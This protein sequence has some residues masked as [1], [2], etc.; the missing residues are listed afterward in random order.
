MNRKLAILGVAVVLIG[1][2]ATQSFYIVDE[3]EQALIVQFGDPVDQVVEPGLN[4]KIPFIQRVIR[5]DDRILSLD[6]PAEQVILG[7]QRRLVVDSFARFK[8][9]DP[10][11]FY[12][13]VRTLE[14]GRERLARTV[15][16]AVRRVL[17]N[18]TQI[19][20]L[21]DQRSRIMEEIQRQVNADALSFGIDIVDVRLGRVDLPEETEQAVF[22]RMRSERAREAAEFR[23]E[24]AEQATQI[25][26]RADREATVLLAEAGRE[27]QVLRG[28]GEAQSITILA[29]AYNA[30]PEFFTFYRTLQA[31]RNALGSEDTT[32]VLSPDSEFFRFFGDVDPAEAVGASGGA[33]TA[34]TPEPSEGGAAAPA[35]ESETTPSGPTEE[36]SAAQPPEEETVPAAPAEAE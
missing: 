10:L 26:A 16:S 24:G 14:T 3:T 36:E 33:I 28:E 32:F 27:A 25:R 17:G 7:D 30:N 23:A 22:E 35:P 29:E 6:P 12:Q 21:S 31:Y 4:F 11:L 19:E 1:L 15:N 5:Y 18:T 8:I 2:L 20:I 34:V 13:A 9:V